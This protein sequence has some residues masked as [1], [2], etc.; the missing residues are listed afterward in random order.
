[1]PLLPTASIQLGCDPEFFIQTK[2][3][4]VIGSELVLPAKGFSLDQ[5]YNTTVQD[6]IQVELHP[7]HHHC[8]QSLGANI[9]RCLEGL[10][11]KLKENPDFVLSFDSM[12]E[13]TQEDLEKLSEKSRQLGC[14]PSDNI[15]NSKLTIGVNPASYMKRSAGGHIHLGLVGQLL[16][17]RRE[18]VKPLDILVG[19]LGVLIDRDPSAAERRKVYGRAGE[20][21]EPPHGLEYRTL[22]NFWTR[23]WYLAHLMFGMTR[24]AASAVHE[25]HLAALNHG[26]PY[27]AGDSPFDQLLAAV[28]MPKVVKAINLN[29]RDLA[30]EN[31]EATKPWIKRWSPRGYREQDR[32]HPVAASWLGHFDFFFDRIHKKGLEFWFPQDPFTDWITRDSWLGWEYVMIKA[33]QDRA[34]PAERTKFGITTR[35]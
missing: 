33:I 5:G 9:K 14:Q 7:H 26:V 23:S 10:A 27:K 13:V 15:H 12:V 3:G 6:G 28:E 17:Y 24:L 19:N 29:D 18:I 20:F 30:L 35:Y 4:A 16:N 22:S 1:M 31:W 8:R 25:S 32:T 21:R 34:T 11:A 2:V